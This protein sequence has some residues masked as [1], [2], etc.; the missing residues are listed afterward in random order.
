MEPLL[1]W[2]TAKIKFSLFFIA[3][4][5]S[6]ADFNQSCVSGV[7]VCVCEWCVCV[8]VCVCVCGCRIF[9]RV[10]DGESAR[11]LH[12]L[13]SRLSPSLS[14]RFAEERVRGVCVCVCVRCVCVCVCV[15]V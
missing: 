15:C 12:L 7:S 6:A 4:K 2:L 1:K 14:P 13:S 5:S 9:F 10:C 11:V 3:V 8:C